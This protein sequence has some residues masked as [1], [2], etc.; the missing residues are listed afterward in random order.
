MK[1]LVSEKGQVTI[2]KAV[3]DRL[4]L[5]PGQVLEFEARGGLL[6]GRKRAAATR[7]V[8]RLFGILGPLDVDGELEKSRGKAWNRAQDA[9]R[10]HR[11]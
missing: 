11:R 7:A 1:S 6:V 10:A 2:P 3:R 8:D 5:K 4:G 9:P